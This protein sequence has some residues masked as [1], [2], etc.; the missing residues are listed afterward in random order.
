M[1]RGDLNQAITLLKNARASRV[2]VK[3][4][5]TKAKAAAQAAPTDIY[6]GTAVVISCDEALA[7]LNDLRRATGTAARILEEADTYDLLNEINRASLI[8]QLERVGHRKV[9]DMVDEILR[10]REENAA[11]KARTCSGRSQ[12]GG[13]HSGGF[14]GVGM[15]KFSVKLDMSE[16]E[17][18]NLLAMLNGVTGK[19]KPVSLETATREYQEALR[20]A[21]ETYASRVTELLK[22]PGAPIKIDVTATGG[23]TKRYADGR[24]AEMIADPAIVSSII[25]YE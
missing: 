10:L 25:A 16:F 22:Q 15:P 20:E 13:F 21:A 11:L 9:T 17:R 7:H 4:A 19:P 24:M 3:A 6:A 12:T 5:I 2:H 8:H 23:F 18:S 14:V 1:K